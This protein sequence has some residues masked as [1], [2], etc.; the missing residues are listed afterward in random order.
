MKVSYPY[1]DLA[2]ILKGLSIFFTMITNMFL[3]VV[4]ITL[5]ILAR[6]ERIVTPCHYL[7]MT[8]ISDDEIFLGEKEYFALPM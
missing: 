4:S 3:C 5:P 8:S 6:D 7:S 1:Y 2:V